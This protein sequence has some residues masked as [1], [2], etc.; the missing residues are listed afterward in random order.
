MNTVSKGNIPYMGKQCEGCHLG[1]S[2]TFIWRHTHT[3]T[4]VRDPATAVTLIN[5]GLQET[6][7]W[8]QVWNCAVYGPLNILCVVPYPD[9]LSNLHPSFVYISSLSSCTLAVMQPSLPRIHDQFMVDGTSIR[10]RVGIEAN[11]IQQPSG[12]ILLVPS[13]QFL[14]LTDF[15]VLQ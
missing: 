13:T 14:N 6:C 1:S 12:S 2:C 4:E 11:R 7:V 9:M 15:N 3:H 5:G 10:W 8:N